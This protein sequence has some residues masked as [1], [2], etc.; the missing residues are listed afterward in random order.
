MP[1]SGRLLTHVDLIFCSALSRAALLRV[2]RRGGFNYLYF[3]DMNVTIGI[4]RYYCFRRCLSFI[5]MFS[6][7]HSIK[8]GVVFPD[9]CWATSRRLRL[10]PLVITHS[11]EKM[12]REVTFDPRDYKNR[13]A[14]TRTFLFMENKSTAMES[15]QYKAWLWDNLMRVKIHPSTLESVHLLSIYSAPHQVDWVTSESVSEGLTALLAMLWSKLH[16]LV[17]DLLLLVCHNDRE[18]CVLMDLVA[19]YMP[20]NFLRHLSLDLKTSC[21][22]VEE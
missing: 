20:M 16:P 9:A 13:F 11:V 12:V 3:T 19:K 7:L 5:H 2:G 1:C 6:N 14:G 17:A 4:C 22:S 15:L 18:K 8:Q 10:P 21:I